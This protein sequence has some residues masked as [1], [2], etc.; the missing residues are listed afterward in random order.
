MAVVVPRQL[1]VRPFRGSAAI[2]AGLVT[3]GALRGPDYQCLLPGVYLAADTAVDATAGSGTAN[4]PVTT[5]CGRCRASRSPYR[6][7]KFGIEYEGDYHRDRTAFRR[8]LARI[9]AMHAAGWTILRVTA[10]DIR[11]PVPLLH[12]LRT[13]L[14]RASAAR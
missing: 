9:N 14:L 4:G 2:A 10:A 3:R 11:N 12:Q 13:L 6:D 7:A 8:D 5:R 1:R